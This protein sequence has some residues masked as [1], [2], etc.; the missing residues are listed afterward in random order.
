VT[1][2]NLLTAALSYAELGWRIHPLHWMKPGGACSCGNPKCDRSKAKHPLIAHWPKV[3]SID[4]DQIKRW[5]R[6]WPH[7]NIGIVT[8]STSGV[9]VLDVDPRNGGDRTAFEKL[10]GELPDTPQVISGSGGTHDYFVCNTYTPSPK[11]GHGI[12]FLADGNHYVVAPPSTH[13]SGSTYEWELSADIEDTAISEMP[14]WL[15]ALVLQ[16]ATTADVAAQTLPHDLPHHEVMGLK[17]SQRIKRIITEGEKKG[18]RSEALASVYTAMHHG[19][20]SHGDIASV[21]L[22]PNNGISEKVWEQ[23]NPRS[24]VYDQQT[25][26][27]VAKDIARVLAKAGPAQNKNGTA[28]APAMPEMWR[29]ENGQQERDTREGEASEQPSNEPYTYLT[30]DSTPNEVYQAIHTHKPTVPDLMSVSSLAA[31]AGFFGQPAYWAVIEQYLRD[32]R[33]AP[34]NARAMRKAVQDYI[35]SQRA[36]II[37][38]VEYLDHLQANKPRPLQYQNRLVLP[39][40]GLGVIGGRPKLGKSYLMLNLALAVA[41]GGKFISSFDMAH[42]G[43]V[44][45]MALED[46]RERIYG[47]VEAL[48]G[49]ESIWPSTLGV[50]YTSPR[51]NE[52]R[53]CRE[54]EEWFAHVETPRLVVVDIFARVQPLRRANG[55]IYQEDYDAMA[56]LVTLAQSY[57]V[58]IFIVTHLSKAHRQVED[59]AEAI[60]GSTGITGGTSTIWAMSYVGE[61]G[62]DASLSIS[63]KDVP[64]WTIALQRHELQ[65]HM[66]WKAIGDIDKIDIGETR[67]EVMQAL[68]TWNGQS[69]DIPALRSYLGREKRSFN[70]LIE[71][72]KKDGLIRGERGK[73]VLTNLGAE[74]MEIYKMGESGVPCVPHVRCVP[75]GPHGPQLPYVHEEKTPYGDK[76]ADDA[77]ETIGTVGAMGATSRAREGEITD[78]ELDELFRIE[79]ENAEGRP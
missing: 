78:A 62:I 36:R 57:G 59:V 34:E 30:T 41:T 64:G 58:S 31:L 73:L 4:A 12:D 72:M 20:Y 69:P 61:S 79:D 51:M 68:Y 47:R 29:N 21:V 13:L 5:W 3:A 45:Y 18:N 22:D 74:S 50:V 49:Q 67:L 76:G 38:H 32:A 27:W 17:V 14:G 63:G 7:A 11:L 24:P 10:H 40:S 33:A 60:M 77:K 66:D 26:G 39:L 44:L 54:L 48:I 70:R 15:A 46:N 65:G 8:G 52:G 56:E 19:G 28:P 43:H 35:E 71:R 23:K 6:K 1:E 37:A 16:H 75:H 2:S 55:D 42:P 9:C 53:L 25:R